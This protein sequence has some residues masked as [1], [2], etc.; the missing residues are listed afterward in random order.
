MT[1]PQNLIG[2][3]VAIGAL[4]FAGGMLASGGAASETGARA[5]GAAD[6]SP[7]A[8]GL[9]QAAEG[10]SV[11]SCTLLTKAEATS[12]LGTDVSAVENP[13][14]CT[15]VA[16]DGS[17][18]AVSVSVPDYSGNRREF[19]PGVEQAAHALEGT[20]QAISAGDEGYA[21]VSPM[22]SEGLARVG[23]RY[24][25]IVLTKAEGTAS[26]QA[27]KLNGLLQSAFGRL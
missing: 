10:T 2:A 4:A 24:V 9:A 11:N 25:V 27:D 6:P 7:V 17:A 8:A 13:S 26:A 23:D 20:F 12:A 16:M 21:I 15:Y 5:D 18:R 19:A 14:Q 3:A 22:V 1:S